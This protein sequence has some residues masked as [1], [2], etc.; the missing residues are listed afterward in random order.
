M[1]RRQQHWQAAADSSDGVAAVLF[2]LLAQPNE[3]ERGHDCRE[4][5]VGFRRNGRRGFKCGVDGAVI[6]W[7]DSEAGR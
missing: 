6:R 1:T 3:H 5:A 7:I 2:H 4:H